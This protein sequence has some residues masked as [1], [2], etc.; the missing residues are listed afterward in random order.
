MAKEKEVQSTMITY[1]EFTDPDF[2]EPSKFFVR[3]A[4]GDR[5]YYHTRERKVAQA[6][7]DDEWG[8][9]KYTVASGKLDKNGEVSVRASLNSKSYAGQKLVSIRNSQGRGL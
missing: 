1:E 9:G 8:V 5:C 7:S 4:T 6:Q 3:V 2:R